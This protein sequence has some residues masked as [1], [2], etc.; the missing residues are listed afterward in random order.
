MSDELRLRWGI[1]GCARITRRGLVPGIRASHT[2]TLHALASFVPSK[3]SLEVDLATNANQSFQLADVSKLI[4][5]FPADSFAAIGAPDLGSTISK[6][7]DQLEKAGAVNKAAIDQQLSTTGVTLND[8]TSALGDFGV[9]AE[10]TDKATLQGASVITSN[11]SSKVKDLISTISSLA[12]ASGQ[13][14]VTNAQVGNGFRVVDPRQIGRQALTVTSLGDRIVIGYGDKATKQAATGGG[15]TLADDP[16]Y[17]Q[18][19]GA[20]GNG[21]SGYVSLTKVFQLADAL[22]AIKNPGYQQA[23]SYLDK[24]SF[25]AIGSS[26]SGDFSTTKVIVGVHG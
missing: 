18:A 15:P 16:T 21:L 3:D 10:G 23:R 14:G 11:S 20:V 7:V 13:P 8:I 6:T 19:L 12:A 4:G 26:K 22:G 1:L 5:T 25:A 17:K 24:L 9:F 2:G